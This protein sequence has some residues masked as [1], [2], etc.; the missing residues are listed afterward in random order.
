VKKQ[1][2]GPAALVG[3]LLLLGWL[4]VRRNRA[5]SLAT[6]ATGQGTRAYPFD[7]RASA[8]TYARENGWTET[9]HPGLIYFWENGR[10]KG[11][12]L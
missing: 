5:L 4:A 7:S 2:L 8:A 10:V 6:A 1:L 12:D 3:V 9:N 11:D